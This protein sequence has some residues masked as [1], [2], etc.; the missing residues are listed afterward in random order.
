MYVIYDIVSF[1]F[2]KKSTIEFQ[3]R[4]RDFSLIY[5]WF[6]SHIVEDFEVP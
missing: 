6:G 4:S 3:F 5:F 1:L 2:E